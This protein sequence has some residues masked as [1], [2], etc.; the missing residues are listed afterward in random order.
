MRTRKG[1]SRE[2]GQEIVLFG[3]MLA[4]VVVVGGVLAINLVWLRAQWTALQEAAFSAAAAGSLQT[5]EIPGVRGLDEAAA[6]DVAIRVLADNLAA[7]PF[8]DGDPAAI[9]QGATIQVYANPP[10]QAPY[11]TLAASVPVRLPWNN[12]RLSLPIS[13]VSRAGESPQ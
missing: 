13:A 1:Q 11:V 10:G 9:A 12:V 7:L 4:A 6:R 5:Q 2:E 3:V 8:L